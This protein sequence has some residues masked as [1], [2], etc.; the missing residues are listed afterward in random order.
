[1][2]LKK[3]SYLK[4]SVKLQSVLMMT[5]G[6]APTVSRKYVMLKLYLGMAASLPGCI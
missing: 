4:Y 5:T 6:C 1:M 2:F 3:K